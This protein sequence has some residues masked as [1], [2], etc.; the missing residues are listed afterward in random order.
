MFYLQT[1]FI[2]TNQMTRLVSVMK[3]E[4]KRLVDLNNEDY[5]ISFNSF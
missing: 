2:D 1:T 5:Y 4:A 3:G